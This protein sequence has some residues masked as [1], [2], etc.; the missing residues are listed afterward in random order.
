MPDVTIIGAGPA[1]CIAAV[2]LC[3]TG[4]DVTLIEQHR[5]PRDKVCGESLSATGVEVLQR[6]GLWE[7]ILNLQPARLVRTSLHS[8]QGQNVSLK[9]PRPMWGL[10]R[11][12][13]D[14]ELLN[15]AREAGARILQ[16][17]R[18]ESMNGELNVRHLNDNRV[19]TLRPACVLLADGKGALL[20]NRPRATTDFGIKAHF[21]SV[22]GPP[23]AV[24]LFGVRGHYVGLA[25]IEGGISNAAFNLP[26]KRLEKTGGDFDALWREMIS[27]NCTLAQRFAAAR[28]TG[29]WLTSPLPRFGVA[30]DWPA[31]VIPLGN[32]A[33]ALE[34]IG[35]EGMGL[36]MRSAEMAAKALDEAR[37]SGTP[38]P[39]S[40]LRAQFNK[41]WR[42]RRIACRGVAK[43]LSSPVLAGPLLDWAAGSEDLSRGVLEWMGKD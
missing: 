19:E 7:R 18:C 3:R 10:S 29:E 38:L 4:W 28:R 33:A 21:E 30:R 36:A 42:K 37:R 23:D 12:A 34:P 25:P 22:D 16:P 2:L 17:A 14:F 27:E 11:C 1:G 43:L 20:P 6:A 15:A 26:A 41:L 39:A 40:Q 24:E 8:S 13:M 35:G 9:L 31:N 32:A 5:F